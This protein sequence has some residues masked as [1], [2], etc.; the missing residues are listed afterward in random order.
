[1]S[2]LFIAPYKLGSESAKVLAHSLTCK[3]VDGTKIFRPNDV[4]INW[5]NSSLSPRGRPRIINRP[6]AVALAANKITSFKVFNQHGVATLDWTTR[7]EEAERWIDQGHV[8]YGRK[9]INGHSGRG[10]IVMSYDGD[11]EFRECS[12]Y[13]KGVIKAHEYRVH[14]FNGRAIDIQKKRRRNE[15][16]SN[17]YIKNIDNGWVFCRDGAQAPVRVYEESI[18]AVKALGLDFGAVDIVYKEKDNFVAVLE[19]N[20]SP[21]LE[22]VT[23]KK[24]QEELC[25]LRQKTNMWG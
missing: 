24:Y 9:I 16:N 21:G 8:V 25:R 12:L 14:V 3:R 20:T 2:R 23:L 10:I 1:M 13:T 22:G 5:G 15:S 4:I 11:Q 18:K 7:R 17:D 6:D 19:V